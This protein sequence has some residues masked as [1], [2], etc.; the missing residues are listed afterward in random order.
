MKR[1]TTLLLLAIIL[2]ISGLSAQESLV[3]ISGVVK[4]RYNHRILEYANVYIPGTNIGTI[5]NSDGEFTIKVPKGKLPVS[6]EFSHLGYQN[7]KLEV[8]EK[9]LINQEILLAPGVVTLKEIT[10]GPIYPSKI[11]QQAI[12]NVKKNYSM[13]PGMY[14]A[15]YREFAQKRRNYINI[16]EAVVDVY[17][18]PYSQELDR[19]RVRIKKGR[20]MVSPKPSDTLDV[21][22]EGGPV[23]ANTMDIVKTPGVLLDFAYQSYYDYE[24]KD[25]VIIN[26]RLNIAIDFKPRVDIP[27]VPLYKGTI[28]IDRENYAISRIEFSMDMSD[29]DKVTTYMLRR[30]PAGLRFRPN[31][32]SYLVTYRQD[33]D[34]YY[35]NYVRTELKF[36]CD[37]KRKLFATNYTVVSEMV[38]T[39]REDNPQETIPYR[40]SF[41]IAQIL[42][43]K[44]Q[45]FYD[46][47]FWK[48]YNIIEPTESLEFAVQKLKKA[49]E[50]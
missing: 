46:E 49:I 48:D 18:T 32:L 21:K 15:F 41:T 31:S 1:L 2:G 30:K 19:D 35:L 27:D 9:N 10:V 33:G 45:D 50:K 39:D 44:V 25:F 6:I 42:S 16:S 20:R 5:T 7:T 11:V 37:W 28:Y 24:F 3:T 23:I 17:K 4:N 40:Q 26:D 12:M 8:T 14:Q 29:R 36:N 22:L 47:E 43:D 34:K 13:Q 38:M